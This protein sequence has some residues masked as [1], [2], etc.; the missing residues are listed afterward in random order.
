MWTTASPAGGQLSYYSM[1]TLRH[2]RHV[3]RNLFEFELASCNRLSGILCHCIY[4][5]ERRWG[6]GI[7]CFKPAKTCIFLRET[8]KESFFDR[9]CGRVCLELKKTCVHL[10]ACPSRILCR[11]HF[12]NSDEPFAT[13]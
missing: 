10:F 6:G 9:N 3:M 13:I 7:P 5:F 11:R 1:P 8:E 2:V 4:A 12:P